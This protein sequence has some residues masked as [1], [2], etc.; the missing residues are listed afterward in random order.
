[1]IWTINPMTDDP[2]L[3]VKVL[4]GINREK[5]FGKEEKFYENNLINFR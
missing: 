2:I 3:R 4:K 1:M 5:V